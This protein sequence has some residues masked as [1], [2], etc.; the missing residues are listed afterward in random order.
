MADYTFDVQ[1]LY[2]EMMMADA[3][4]FA[5]A[6]NIFD[7]ASF[8]RKLQPIAKFIK[9]YVEQ[10][11]VMPE[12]DQ[13]NASNDIKLKTAKEI[14]PAHFNWLLDE[15]ELFSRHKAMERAIL[16]SAD[17]LERGDYAP[18]EDKI[19]AAVGI[20]LTKDLGTDYFEDPKG[21]LEHLKN[22]NGQISTGWASVDKKLFGGFNRGELN[23]FAGGSGAGKSLFLQNLAVNWS[24]AGLNVCYVSFELSEALV[25]MRLDAMVT[26]IPTRKIF[27]EIDNVE[28]KI[29]MLHKKAGNLQIKYLP[30][31]S[32][33][34]DIKAYIKELELK[35][36]K[37]IDCIL[38]DYLDLMMP[39]SKKISPA[40]LFIK[41]KYVSEE[42]RNYGA[43]SKMLMVT[44]S[45]L[46][47]ASV[48][49]IEFDHSHISGGLSKVQTADNVIGIFT[50][51][52]MKERGRYQIQF[53]KTRSSSGVGQKI[54][55]EFDVD[56]LR[57]RDL[58]ED[59]EYQQF[60]K[61]SSTIYDSLKTKSKVS[62][63][64]DKNDARDNNE[65][66]PRK[67]DDIG[68]VKATVEG[69]K[70]RQLLNELHSDEEQ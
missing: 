32:N 16:E 20:S 40:D 66:D 24:L 22:S 68:K 28:M 11:K 70:L 58:A 69:G 42:L 49:E 1:K 43:E 35:N 51:R 2:L 3:E 61:Q 57:I 41:D 52:A 13:V 36:K 21:R 18:V 12:V 5:R 17:L 15:F 54:D 4:S 34:N 23:I 9:D 45:Q 14:D 39:K 62:T 60:K 55:L 10:Y 47:R 64:G 31:G 6:Q 38:I 65:I 27:P 50:S 59:P 37:K 26:G 67:G 44:A 63:S 25:A 53:M 46:N 30:S 7:P 8:D 56:T 48:E 19:K 29:K 33:V